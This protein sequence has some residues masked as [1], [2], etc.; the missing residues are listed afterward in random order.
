MFIPI[1]DDV[2]R[3]KHFPR[4]WPFV[5]GI[6]RSMVNSPHKGQWRGTLM[7][8]LICVWI[9]AWV[10][11]CEAGV[12]R[13]HRAHY[14]VP[15]M[16]SRLRDFAISDNKTSDCLVN[17]ALV[18]HCGSLL[19]I[20]ITLAKLYFYFSWNVLK[21]NFRQ[22]NVR[23]IKT[24]HYSRVNYFLKIWTQCWISNVSPDFSVYH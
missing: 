23:S 14:D 16:I 19:E 2:I 13:R 8:S 1:H 6:H 17:R 5:R 15:E 10:N 7:F 22:W 21:G 12:L 4:Y 20:C 9:N 18:T 3:W 11:N 24:I